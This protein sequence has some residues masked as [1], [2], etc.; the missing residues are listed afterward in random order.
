[1]LEAAASA[2]NH[3]FTFLPMLALVVGTFFGLIS[4]AMP[5]GSLP[6]L[7][8]LMGFAF[9]LDPYIAIPLAIG[10]M[11]V[12]STTDAIPCILMG[13]PGSAS[14]Q[15]T[16]LDG[17]P[18][19][20]QGRAGEALAAAYFASLLGGIIGAIALAASLPVARALLRLFGSP[21]FFLMGLIGIAMVGIVSSGALVKGLLA[22][23]LGLAIA[24]VGFDP[25]SGVPRATFGIQYLWDGLP[26]IPVI[27]GLFAIPEFLDMVISDSPIARER[28][29][30]LKRDV[31]KGRVEGIKAVLRHK[32]LVLRASLIGVFIG[33][34]PGVSGSTAHWLAYAQAMQTEKG[35]RET[36]GKGDIRGVIAPESANNSVDGGDLIPTVT[37]G[38]P[39]SGGNAVFLGFL[40]LLGFQPGP[41]MLTSHLDIL[42]LMV[43]CLALANIIAT[44]VALYFTPLMA[45][46][47]LV[48]PNVLVPVVMAMLT[49]SAFQA[50]RTMGDLVVVAAFAGLGWFMKRYGWPRPPII[51]A[52][53]LTKLLEKYLWLSVNTFGLAM[54]A[55]PQFV[56]MLALTVLAVFYSLGTQAKARQRVEL[57]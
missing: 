7:V 56:V 5:G 37:F 44:V 23:T 34:M 50:T 3:L 54:L 2:F 41:Q 21:E 48:R 8:V 1:M 20:K 27:V 28:M 4:G 6:F 32:F 17:Y 10:H 36:F 12:T 53:V 19:A 40:I 46:I 24:M 47:S 25:I 22:G 29:D 55:R 57:D 38:I 31:N 15:A 14:A 9:H 52:L 18:M 39:G 16:I 30:L 35:A 43:W 26:L 13:I 45:K 33:I 51:I 42:L 11:A 49:I